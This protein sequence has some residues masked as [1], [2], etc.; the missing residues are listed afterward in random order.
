MTFIQTLSPLYVLLI[1]LVIALAFIVAE[2]ISFG[3]ILVFFGLG[4]VIAGLCAY[5]FGI[6]LEWQLLIFIVS[7]LIAI[8]LLRK[9]GI[10]TFRGNENNTVDDDYHNAIIGQ[11]AMVTKDIVPPALGEV[12]Y[13]GSFWPATA[14]TA[15]AAGKMVEITARNNEDSLTLKVK[16]L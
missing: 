2:L 6:A 8:I 1:W 15:I 16:A 11:T 10:K 13:S 14:D 4:A 3:F 5:F 7:S 9:L 12:K